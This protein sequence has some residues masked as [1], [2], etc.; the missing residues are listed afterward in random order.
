MTALTNLTSEAKIV[1]NTKDS[2]VK[3]K[4]LTEDNGKIGPNTKDLCTTNCVNH[5]LKWESEL[6]KPQQRWRGRT[7]SQQVWLL[8][9]G[10][11]GLNFDNQYAA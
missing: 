5:C 2:C 6:T 7:L 8:S 3:S 11:A 9:R 4:N 10:E 1:L